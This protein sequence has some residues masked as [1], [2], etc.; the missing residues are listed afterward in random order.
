MY[1]ECVGYN[2]IYCHPNK[3]AITSIYIIYLKL[4]KMLGISKLISS[5]KKNI[6]K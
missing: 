3:N 6:L 2:T 4:Y 5:Y 1:G